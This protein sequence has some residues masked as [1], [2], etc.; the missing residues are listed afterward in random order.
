MS[1]LDREMAIYKEVIN[2]IDKK[3]AQGKGLN[4]VRKKLNKRIKEIE[5]LKSYD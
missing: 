4:S 2:L 5:Y 1:Y 3:E